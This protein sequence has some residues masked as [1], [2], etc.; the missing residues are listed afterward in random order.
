MSTK[1]TLSKMS[2]ARSMLLQ[3]TWS[4]FWEYRIR[5]E[6]ERLYHHCTYAP[7]NGPPERPLAEAA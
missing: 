7:V 5:K 2:K 6:K 3:H 1:W 4:E